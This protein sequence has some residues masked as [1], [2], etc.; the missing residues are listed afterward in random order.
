MED[1]AISF[2][3]TP[4]FEHVQHSS[5]SRSISVLAKVPWFFLYNSP[6]IPTFLTFSSDTPV[7]LLHVQGSNSCPLQWEYGALNTRP[8]GDA[9]SPS[10]SNQC[11]QTPVSYPSLSHLSHGK[12]WIAHCLLLNH[13][14]CC[15]WGWIILEQFAA[16]EIWFQ[17]LNC[18]RVPIWAMPREL[19][20][21]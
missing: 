11:L 12:K 13:F 21:L 20:R 8:P 19:L 4:N 17:A 10:V 1:D 9:P 7:E 6:S 18:Q 14:I 5:K 2:I 3:Q 16:H 15:S